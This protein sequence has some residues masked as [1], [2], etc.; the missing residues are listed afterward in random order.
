MGL[1][2]R[3]FWTIHWSRAT[4]TRVFAAPTYKNIFHS[5]E[6]YF[7]CKVTETNLARHGSSPNGVLKDCY[8]YLEFDARKFANTPEAKPRSYQRCSLSL[9]GLV[10]GFGTSAVAP[11][12]AIKFG[13]ASS[14]TAIGAVGLG[15]ADGGII[16]E[17]PCSAFYH[18][19]PEQH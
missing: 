7:D 18:A 15:Q 11:G 2:P 19:G 10:G 3:Y 4:I 13:L 16:R 8:K 6:H 9:Y 5:M 1:W 14:A 17:C 12:R